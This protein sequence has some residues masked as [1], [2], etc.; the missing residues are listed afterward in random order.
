MRL[1]LLTMTVTLAAQAAET[2][3][4]F[5]DLP[6]AVQAAARKEI[7]NATITGASSEKEHGRMTYEVETK[8]NGKGRDLTFAADGSLTEVEEE[9]SL[10]TLPAAARE[11]LR[12]RASGGSI[13]KVEKVMAGGAVS[14]EA[15]VRTRAGR[16]TE[17]GVNPDGAPHKED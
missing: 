14:Y 17:I 1:L 4:K 13:R 16:D 12:K 10:D 8:V 9:T 2:K 15:D 6:A 11:A 7:G 5:E 3:M